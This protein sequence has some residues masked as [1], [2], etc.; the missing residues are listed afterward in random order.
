MSPGIAFLRAFLFALRSQPS[1]ALAALYWLVTGRTVRARNR[2]HMHPDEASDAYRLWIADVEGQGEAVQYARLAAERWTYNP[3]ISVVVHRR[4]SAD[5]VALD[6]LVAMMRAQTYPNWELILVSDSAETATAA[7]NSRVR[8]ADEPAATGG[9][10]LRIGLALA[11]GDY[12]LPLPAQGSLP[13]AALF[14]YAEALQDGPSDLLFGDNDQVGPDGE[15]HRPWLKSEWNEELALAQ[16]YLSQAMVVSTD[17]ARTAVSCARPHD[18]AAA[19][20]LGLAVGRRARSVVRHVAHVQAHVAAGW[21][22][23]PQS[24]RLA[25]V[26]AQLSN[27]QSAALSGPHGTIRVEWPLPDEL[28]LVSIIVPTRDKVSLLRACLTSLEART[29]YRPFEVIVVDNGSERADTLAYLHELDRRPGFTVLR[30]DRPYNYA[31]LNNFAADQ[32]RG[33]YL[34]LLNN[35]TEVIEGEWLTAMMRQAHRSHVGAVGARLLYDDGS[36]QHAGVAIGLGGSAKHPHR[37]QKHDAEGYF[38]RTH[39][40][41]YVSAVTGACLLVEKSKFMGVGGLDE[42]SLAIAFNDVD[43]CLKLQRAGFRNVY[44][45]QATLLHHESKSRAR[46]VSPQH[47]DRYRRELR[48]LQ[49]RWGT[50]DYVDPLHHVHLDPSS[51]TF[52]LRR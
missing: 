25:V 16:D 51:E 6:G 48:T 9:E 46:D 28:P 34:C 15:R 5:Q 52:V 22:G 40:A 17:A 30:D 41:H 21:D 44:T 23:A 3:L 14:R 42:Q 50:R 20:A 33:D 32:A 45:P 12:L 4:E 10:A 7:P 18:A 27:T 36:I 1:R 24:E 8:V 31:Q 43:L 19:Y 29:T 26:N 37:F 13:P 49:A 47:A 35:D 38:A 2:L 39:A 11:R